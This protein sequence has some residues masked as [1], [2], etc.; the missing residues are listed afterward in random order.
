MKVTRW[1]LPEGYLSGTTLRGQ[2]GTVDDLSRP[3][4]TRLLGLVSRM[5][6][7]LADP[8]A[9]RDGTIDPSVPMFDLWCRPLGLVTK[10]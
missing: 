9:V 10:G 2:E 5:W 8:T 7:P 4:P 1:G 3:A 6:N